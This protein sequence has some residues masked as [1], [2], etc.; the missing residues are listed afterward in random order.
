MSR[1]RDDRDE[2]LK[3][4]REQ[5]H[6]LQLKQEEMIEEA[7]HEALRNY[8]ANRE[9][10]LG[11]NQPTSQHNVNEYNTHGIDGSRTP[12]G[13]LMMRCNSTIPPWDGKATAGESPQ[14][15]FR[16]FKVQ[17]HMYCQ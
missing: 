3:F 17:I 10:A 14:S 7:K 1:T 6:D 12:S 16:H 9:A 4:L 2:E 5:L 15:K 11:V 8:T 13:F